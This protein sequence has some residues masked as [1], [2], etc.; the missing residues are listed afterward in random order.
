MPEVKSTVVASSPLTVVRRS[1]LPGPSR[2]SGVK[3][4][5]SKTF[6]AKGSIAMWEG[7]RSAWPC[8]KVMNS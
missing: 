6:R 4:I 5:G 1:S 8:Q 7:A 2:Q 3:S